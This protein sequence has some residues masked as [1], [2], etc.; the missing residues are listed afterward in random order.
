[1]VKYIQNPH[2]IVKPETKEKLEKLKLVE[3]ETFD[4][5]IQRL[6]KNHIKKEKKTKPKKL[7]KAS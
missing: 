7:I 4:S 3:T 2:I 5:V 6:I 1:M